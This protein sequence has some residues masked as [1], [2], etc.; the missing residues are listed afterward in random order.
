MT[1]ELFTRDYQNN[2]YKEFN[3]KLFLTIQLQ[4][5]HGL[6]KS[7]L[8]IKNINKGLKRCKIRL[9]IQSSLPCML[10]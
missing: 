1:D 4:F 8:C 2:P 9:I 7:S 6:V 5:I 10:Y 3:F